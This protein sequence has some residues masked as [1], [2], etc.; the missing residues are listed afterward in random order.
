[1][2]VAD[3]GVGLRGVPTD[4]LP[5]T[6]IGL[7][8]TRARLEHLYGPDHRFELVPGADGGAVARVRVP[9]RSQPGAA[10]AP[11][12][13]SDPEPEEPTTPRP[14]WEPLGW[15]LLLALLAL[16]WSGNYTRYV[17]TRIGDRVVTPAAAYGC[18]L[19][20]ALVWT[21]MAYR[22]F[23]VGAPRRRG[24]RG[25]RALVRVHAGPAAAAALLLLLNDILV[26]AVLHGWNRADPRVALPVFGLSLAFYVLVYGGVAVLADALEYARRHR[27]QELVA[28]RL[29]AD[30]ARAE[31][32][33]ASAELR[34]LRPR[35]SPGYVQEVLRAVRRLCAEQPRAAEELVV[36]LSELLRQELTGAPREEGALEEEMTA[37][38]PYLRVERLRLGCSL[39]VGWAV[40][41]NA[42]DALV[43]HRVLQPLIGALLGDLA[44]D[45]LSISARRSGEC[46]D[47]HVSVERPGAGR[48]A[49]SP[50]GGQAPPRHPELDRLEHRL[51]RLYGD[52][53]ELRR[54]PGA[55]L[56][57]RLPWHEEWNP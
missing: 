46:L 43:P 51:T 13:W 34:A 9:W 8:N 12:G 26:G 17:G 27:D 14:R 7:A 49:P 19:S 53:F 41:G 25:V 28:L 11:Q 24:S 32:D 29:R 38:E 3:D 10:D 57:L 36:R 20:T 44:A 50:A 47:L 5:G 22:A 33:R 42:L 16:V 31:L 39:E 2:E 40:D 1:V 52:G 15:L 37:L 45:R 4:G 35:S 18:L 55:A 48:A 56:L 6:G 23:R 30:L 54:V 21:H